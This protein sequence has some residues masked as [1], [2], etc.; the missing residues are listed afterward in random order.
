VSSLCPSEPLANSESSN[1]HVS[2]FVLERDRSEEE[3]FS[4][5]ADAASA[6]DYNNTGGF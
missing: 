1:A 3:G 6:V 2:V 4:A 5:L